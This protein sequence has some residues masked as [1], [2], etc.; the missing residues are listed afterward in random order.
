MTSLL[1]AAAVF[2]LLH[3]LVSG[4]RLRDAI[5]GAIGPGPYM[6]LF[7]LA[8]IAGLTWLG[9]AFA[10]ARGD[11]GAVAYWEVT[12]ITRHLQL[13]LQ[14][15][16]MLLIVPGLT[17]P[18]PTSVR[19]EGALERPDVVKGM[20]RITRHPFLWGVAV[21][22]L[23]HLLVNGDR[24]S[25]VLFGSMLVLALFGT[26]SIDAKRKRTLG[27]TWDGFASQTS[28][29]PFGAILAGKQSLKLGEIGWWRILLA[30]AVWVALAWGH[31]HMFGVAALP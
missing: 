17:T 2:V 16:A 26:S 25:L 27:A 6:G 29:V 11:P 15:L 5:T 22:A 13:G 23:G 24:A 4:T 19:Q 31:P 10:A 28:N 21:W 7:S 8:S 1:A 14:L 20:L 30:V 3:L 9:F 18:N 12:P